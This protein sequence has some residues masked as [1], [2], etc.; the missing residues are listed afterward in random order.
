MLSFSAESGAASA[1]VGGAAASAAVGGTTS[2]ASEADIG[3]ARAAAGR[4]DEAVL[5]N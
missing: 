2:D 3:A 4:D 5:E 1:A